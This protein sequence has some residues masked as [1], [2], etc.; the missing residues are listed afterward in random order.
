M[1]DQMYFCVLCAFDG[2]KAVYAVQPGDDVLGLQVLLC[3]GGIKSEVV[4]ETIVLHPCEDG[5]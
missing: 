4:G 5:E 2:E 1:N 3:N